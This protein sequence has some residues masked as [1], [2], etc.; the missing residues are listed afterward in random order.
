MIAHCGIEYMEQPLPEWRERYK[1]W[2]DL[3]ADAVI[4]SHP[5]VPQGWEMYNGKPICYSLGNFCFDR[6]GK[7]EAPANWYNSLCCVLDI[8]SKKDISMTIRP[9][10]Y[11]ADT[12][13]ICNGSS[14]DFD[15]YLNRINAVLMDESA[16]LAYVNSFVS[17]LFP[18][19]MNQFSRGGLVHNPFS[20]GFMKG[21][22][23]AVLGRGFLKKE[24]WQNNLQ[25]ESHRWAILRAMKLKGLQ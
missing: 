2:I 25:C 7:K 13:Y 3:G 1:R 15:A 11:N 14:D 23:E 16:Y 12:Q 9:I 10:T 22:A 8:D 5:H 20:I 6:L 24:H 4:A 17:N 19:Y 21:V 18:H